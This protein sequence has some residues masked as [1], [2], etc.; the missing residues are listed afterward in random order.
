MISHEGPV[1]TSTETTDYEGLEVT[2]K[3]TCYTDERG[4]TNR[5]NHRN[6]AVKSKT[7]RTVPHWPY[8][9]LD[10]PDTVLLLKNR[11]ANDH[12]NVVRR[13]GKGTGARMEA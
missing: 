8:R 2:E 11:G 4:K 10:D 5:T 9:W 12:N 13:S 6:M 1:F 3:M 7:P